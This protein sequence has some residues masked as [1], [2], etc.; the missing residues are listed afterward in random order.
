MSTSEKYERIAE[1]LGKE[2]EIGGVLVQIH[3]TRAVEEQ[4]FTMISEDPAL[5]PIIKGHGKTIK[6]IRKIYRALLESGAG[7]WRSGEYVP[8]MAFGS[9]IP[10]RHILH[11][12]GQQKKMSR[13]DWETLAG[14]LVNGNY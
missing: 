6:D 8:V 11:R 3:R 10:L 5:A 7:K 1:M 4:F 14:D 9:A 2:P 12:V 13:R